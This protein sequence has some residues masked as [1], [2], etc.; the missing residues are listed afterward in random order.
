MLKLDYM[1]NNLE[2]IN[3]PKG[4]SI[5]AIVLGVLMILS[6]GMMLFGGSESLISSVEA[7]VLR[8]FYIAIASTDF[9]LPWLGIF[10]I[11]TGAALISKK[12]RAFGIIAAFAFLTNI[13]L[14]GVFFANEHLL[15]SAIGFAL[16]GYLVCNY[17]P[18]WKKLLS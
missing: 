7:G 11:A 12:V 4:S 8:D 17:R 3:N 14:Y 15:T 5:V 18:V 6:G 16:V 10:K 2:I 9:L 13:L 1:K